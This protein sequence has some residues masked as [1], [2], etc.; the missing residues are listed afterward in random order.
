[1]RL[2]QL[3]DREPLDRWGEGPVTLVGDAAHPM[4]PH[5]GQGAAQ[6]L[7]DAVALAA[8]LAD[9]A[10]PI[11][12]LRRY[13]RR[14]ASRTARIVRLSRRNARLGAIENPV[15]VWLR[16]TAIRLVPDA[17]LLRSLIALARPERD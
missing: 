13:E 14:R 5:A 7:E 4:L 6:A 3:F 8:A 9:A 12:G 1:M 17:M 10:D 15:G 11:E 16:D 2:D